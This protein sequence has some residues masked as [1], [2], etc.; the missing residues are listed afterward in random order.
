MNIHIRI[1]GYPAQ[2]AAPAVTKNATGGDI[3]TDLRD[4]VIAPFLGKKDIVYESACLQIHC[5]HDEFMAFVKPCKLIGF[6]DPSSGALCPWERG[7]MYVY[8]SFPY[9]GMSKACQER[10]VPLS[11]QRGQDP[12][13]PPSPQELDEL[14]REVKRKFAEHQGRRDQHFGVPCEMPLRQTMPINIVE[15]SCKRSLVRNGHDAS[16]SDEELFR[17]HE[18]FRIPLFARLWNQRTGEVV[19]T[20]DNSG[21]GPVENTVK[22]MQQICKLFHHYHDIDES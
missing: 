7:R 10:L 3:V 16:T 12:Q 19:W 5:E 17:D 13:P 2:P 20:V 15:D 22:N 8:W 18:S 14:S 11:I 1:G 4:A 21:T 9:M 6:H